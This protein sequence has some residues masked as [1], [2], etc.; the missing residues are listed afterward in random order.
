[1]NRINIIKNQ[2]IPE[3]HFA[4]NNDSDSVIV[5]AIRSPLTKAKGGGL[6]KTPPENILSQLLKEIIDRTKI[7]ISEINDIIIGNTLI[8]GCGFL[9]FRASEILSNINNIPL[10]SVNR[11]CNSGLQAIINGNNSIIAKNC[12]VV[13]AGGIECMSLY[14]FSK[15]LDENLINEKNI[16]DNPLI[17]NLLIPMGLTNENLCEKYN[18][19]RKEQD[20]F[21]MESHIKAYLAQKEGK[22]KKEIIPIRNK[23]NK[24][25]ELDDGIRSN[26]NIKVLNNLKSIFKKNGVTTAG[27]SSQLTDGGA[28]IMMTNREISK[29]YNLEILGKIR[30]Y[31]CVGVPSELMGIGPSIAIPTLLKMENLSY[32]DIDLFEINEAFAGQALYCIK[33]LGIDEKKVNVHGGA[34]ALGHPL[35][36]TGTRLVVAMLNQLDIYQKKRGIVSMCIGTG[37]GAAC[38]IEKE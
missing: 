23:E 7:P 1:M 5:S 8:E 6:Y 17:K 36:C 22:L 18:I 25:I 33:K 28:L 30:N 13:I 27:N 32:D 11:L 2:L 9:P 19:S 21:A 24:I 12:K 4:K 34:I 37:M 38:I 20:N 10:Y 15:M 14:P 29:K 16:N 26:I 35:A 3:A 31:C